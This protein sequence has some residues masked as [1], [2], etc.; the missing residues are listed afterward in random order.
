LPRYPS[1]DR[2]L[3]PVVDESVTWDA[4]RHVI[5]ANDPD[6]LESVEYV[7]VY[8]GKPIP[9]GR[10]SVTLRMRFRDP[11]RTLKH[12][13]VTEQIQGVVKALSDSLNAEIRD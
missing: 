2:D 1:I 6:L 12:E 10:K 9:K 11:D 3:S 8:R 5:E 7:T 13:E 4:I